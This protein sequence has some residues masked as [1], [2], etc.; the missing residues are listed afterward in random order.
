MLAVILATIGGFAVG[1]VWYSVLGKQWMQAIGK[2]EA[3][4]KENSSPL[5]FV[6]AGGAA[7]LAAGLMRHMFVMASIEGLGR[8]LLY[9]AGLGI[10]VVM[11]WVIVH[12]AFSDRPKSL[13]LIDGGH[14]IFAFSIM[15]GI[16]GMM[17]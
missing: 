1:A 8:G 9:G 5:P 3:Q 11:P 13:W 7:L 2:T 15:G 10:F 12:Y 4:I 17:L 16:L 6:I 14:V